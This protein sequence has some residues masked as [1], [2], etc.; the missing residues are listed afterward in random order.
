[1]KLSTALRLNMTGLCDD[2]KAESKRY[3]AAIEMAAF[4][5]QRGFSVVSVEEHHCAENGWLPSPL[6]LAAMIAARTERIAVNVT[7]LLIPL[8]DP[9]KLAEMRTLAFPDRKILAGSTP[10]FDNG[11][12][13]QSAMRKRLRFQKRDPIGCGRRRDGRIKRT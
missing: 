6:I 9:I 2:A 10:V 8:Y 13:V 4:A 12:A 1:M 3:R 11:P 5:D 7:A